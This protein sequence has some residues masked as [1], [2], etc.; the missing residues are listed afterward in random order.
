MNVKTGTASVKLVNI[1]EDLDLLLLSSCNPMT[2][3]IVSSTPIDLQTDEAIS[4]NTEIG[5]SYYVVV[6]GYDG[7]EGSYTLQID[8]TNP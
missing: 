4:F 2:N 6:D 5:K 3:T 1:T 7:A 8:C